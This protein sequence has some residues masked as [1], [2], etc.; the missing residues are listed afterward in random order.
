MLL[1][2]HRGDVRHGFHRHPLSRSIGFLSH[3]YLKLY[4]ARPELAS[5]ENQEQL[6][7]FDREHN[8]LDFFVRTEHLEED[9]LT[10]LEQIP[11]TPS[12]KD[13]VQRSG[14]KWT[15]ASLRRSDYRHYYDDAT[16]KLVAEN[17]AFLIQKHGYR[18][19]PPVA[20]W[21]PLPT[22]S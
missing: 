12:E 15:N 3:R 6:Q 14:L 4:T 20:S 1:V 13:L 5:L 16:A 8:L 10:V 11:I 21:E 7:S 9:L 22:G 19:D 17:D 2:T 18:F